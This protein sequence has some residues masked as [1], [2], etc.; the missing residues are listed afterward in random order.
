MLIQLVFYVLMLFAI[1]ALS[2]DVGLMFLTQTQMQNAADT[3]AL[4][5][6]RQR[7]VA[8]TCDPADSVCIENLRRRAAHDMASFTFDD[9]FNQTPGDGGLN[10]GAGPNVNFG[11]DEGTTVLV[12]NQGYDV[13][14]STAVKPNLQLNFDQADATKRN[15]SYGDMVSGQYGPPFG[16]PACPPI[17]ETT[18]HFENSNYDRT[19]FCVSPAGTALQAPSF[20]VRLR[21][22]D[23]INGNLDIADDNEPGVSRSDPTLPLLFGR[24]TT[25]GKSDGLDYNP[26]LH[27]ITIRATAIA[28]ARPALRV[29]LSGVTQFAILRSNWETIATFTP[30]NVSAYNQIDPSVP[31]TITLGDEFAIA[32]AGVAPFG[33]GVG[34]VPIYQSVGGANRVIGFGYVEMSG[35]TQSALRRTNKIA[36]ANATALVTGAFKAQGPDLQTVFTANRD[37]S[38]SLLLAPVIAR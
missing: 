33:D 25:I 23:H 32:P 38:A 5:G 13:D 22:T 14:S 28:D 12:A 29:G 9:D 7:D 10:L 20:L 2:V 27:G 15:K 36:A 34:Y 8:G 30:A 21:R 37:L 6:L 26:R 3:A 18:P 24:G 17:T 1:A 35:A 31:G 4:E 11:T 19:D 16:D